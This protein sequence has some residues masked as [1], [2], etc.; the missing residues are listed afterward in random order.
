MQPLKRETGAVWPPTRLLTKH[1]GIRALPYRRGSGDRTNLRQA[2]QRPPPS[3]GPSFQLPHLT[4]G[5]GIV[6]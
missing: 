1:H 4:L 3:A 6:K 2:C 5:T